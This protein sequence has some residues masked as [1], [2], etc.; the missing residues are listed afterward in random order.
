MGARKWCQVI[1]YRE[2]IHGD[3]SDS[4]SDFSLDIWKDVDF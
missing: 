2:Y 1:N 4:K 3:L